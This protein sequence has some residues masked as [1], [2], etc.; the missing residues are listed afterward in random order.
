MNEAETRKIV[1]EAVKEQMDSIKSETKTSIDLGLDPFLAHF[2][3][4][5]K[6]VYQCLADFDERLKHLENRNDT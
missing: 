3:D 4:E 6:K 1:T 2:T 5:M